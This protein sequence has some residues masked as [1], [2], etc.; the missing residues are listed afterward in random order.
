[1][2]LTLSKHKRRKS[3]VNIKEKS[4]AYIENEDETKYL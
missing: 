4:E 1:M 2:T 3:S